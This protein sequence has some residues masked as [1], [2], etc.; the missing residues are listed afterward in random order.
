MQRFLEGMRVLVVSGISAG[1]VLIGIGSRLAMLLLRLTSPNRV[2]GVE[3]DDGFIIGQ[4]TLAGTYNLMLLGAAF[5]VIGAAAYLMVSPWLIGPTWFRR[6]T[7][8][9]AAAVVVG[10]MLV[11]A[12]GIDFTVLKPTWLAIGVFVALPG[13][14][15]ALVGVVVDAVR[16]PGSW[17][18]RGRRRWV[19]PLIL[20]ACLPLAI[21]VILV[22]AAVFGSWVL[23]SDL[24]AIDRVRSSAPYA[25]VVRAGW[26][27]IA[28]LGLVAIVNDT[29][30]IAEVVR[31]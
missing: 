23:I 24:A 27:V 25:L 15:G 9:L 19:L 22:A 10:S 12:D 13:L 8:G 1:V 28:I 5:G 3:S 26:L 20:V 6:L 4:V 17:T 2:R 7:T 31:R 18:A 14:F 29:Q 21:V 30:A 11:H 16:R